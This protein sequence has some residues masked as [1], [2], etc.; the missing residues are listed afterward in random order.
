MTS[1]WKLVGSFGRWLEKKVVHIELTQ[2]QGRKHKHGRHC[3]A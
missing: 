1:N 3:Q 2:Q